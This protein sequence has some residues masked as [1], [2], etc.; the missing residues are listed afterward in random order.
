MSSTLAEFLP[1]DNPGDYLFIYLLVPIVILA[2]LSIFT[3]IT[4]HCALLVICL[5]KPRHCSEKMWRCAFCTICKPRFFKSE[6]WCAVSE[7]E[8]SC[9]NPILSTWVMKRGFGKVSFYYKCMQR[10]RR[11]KPGM[12]HWEKTL[13]LEMTEEFFCSDLAVN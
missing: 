4:S 13:H 11:N 3:V 2:T 5:L 10:S 8:F 12:C 7:R 9:C 6:V 1:V